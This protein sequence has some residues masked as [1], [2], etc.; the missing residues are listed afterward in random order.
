MRIDDVNTC[1]MIENDRN[2]SKY[3]KDN[4]FITQLSVKNKITILG[5]RKSSHKSLQRRERNDTFWEVKE[6]QHSGDLKFE[7]ETG[8]TWRPEDE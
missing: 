7:A 3:F 5:R 4:Y 8:Q 2:Y 1:K 6:I